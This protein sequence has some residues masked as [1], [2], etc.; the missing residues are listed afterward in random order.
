MSQ[1]GRDWVRGV[2]NESGRKT[3]C[4]RVLERICYPTRVFDRGNQTFLESVEC[5][6]PS[7][8]VGRNDEGLEYISSSPLFPNLHYSRMI[9]GMESL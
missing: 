2:G 9:V 1:A 7:L 4:E 6:F 3:K 5:F 8:F